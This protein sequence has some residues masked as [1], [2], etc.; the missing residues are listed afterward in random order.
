[1]LMPKRVRWRKQ[2][3]APYDGRASRGN[4]VFTGSTGFR[5]WKEPG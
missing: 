4:E 1:M 2:H 3:K 5:L